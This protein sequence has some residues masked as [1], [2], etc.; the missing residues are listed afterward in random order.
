MKEPTDDTDRCTGNAGTACGR[1]GA[2]VCALCV[3]RR[4][5]EVGL[6]EWARPGGGGARGPGGL[7]LMLGAWGA[8]EVVGRGWVT[9]TGLRFKA[10][11]GQLAGLP[12]ATQN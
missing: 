6:E 5:P 9:R 11:A 4:G 12:A 10:T 8:G 3:R 1:A 2:G 7:G